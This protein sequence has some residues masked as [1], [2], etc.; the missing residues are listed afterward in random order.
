MV[1]DHIIFAGVDISSGRNPV[2]FTALDP[3]LNIV[4]LVNWSVAEA[5][6][7]LKEYPEVLL[8]VNSPDRKAM[9]AH[10]T[11]FKNKLVHAGY[12]FISHD[13][14]YRWIETDSQKCFQAL[15]DQDLLPRRTLEGR[16]QRD[17]ILYD[18]GLQI[19]DPMELFEE[20]TRHKLLQGILPLENLHSSKELDALVAAYVAWRAVQRASLVN[21]TGNFALPAKE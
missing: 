10:S 9:A 6:S 1:S 18:E 16:I 15:C 2:M 11:D 8:A 21:I 5:V 7:C 4:A 17:L 14:P 19:K 12:K 20:I 13:G 3:D